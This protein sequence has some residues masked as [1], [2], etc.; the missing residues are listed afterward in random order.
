LIRFY[1]AARENRAPPGLRLTL[2]GWAAIGIGILIKGP[3]I[4]AVLALTI[5]PLSL[6]DRDWKW[7]R[8]T[9]PLAGIALVLLIVLPWMIAIAF[10]SHG[11]FYQQSLG[12][13]FASKV[14]GGQETHGAPPGYY[15]AL[16]SITLW[17]ATLFLFPAIRFAVLKRTLPAVRFLLIWTAANW[18][19]FELV[20]TKLPHYILPVYPALIGLCALWATAQDE[21]AKWGRRLR[22]F[23]VLQFLIALAALVAAPII[24]P[25]RFGDGG[26]ALLIASACI[27]AIA[28]FAAVAF[29]LRH[30][31]IAAG[32]SAAVSAIVLYATLAAGTAPHLEKIW[33]SPRATAL[34]AQAREPNDPPVTL[35]GY[36][37]PSLVFL[38]GTDTLIDNG[39]TAAASAA[40]QGGLVLVEDHERKAFLGHLSELKGSFTQVGELSGFDYSRGKQEHL[41]LYRTTPSPRPLVK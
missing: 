15:L 21:D 13:D 5:I 37:E 12:H 9:R 23:A 32:A 11:A 33:M 36:V 7:L 20:P 38:L 28:G 27:G 35:A 8:A 1:M 4:A 25:E 6:W 19:V 14:M 22:Y 39:E 41:T 16:A 17:P 30:A 26:S 18:I 34:I 29:F 3:V 24:L 10:A 2:A 31:N 40:R